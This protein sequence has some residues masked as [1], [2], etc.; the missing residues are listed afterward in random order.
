M[1]YLSI[2]AGDVMKKIL[3]TSIAGAILCMALSCQKENFIPA[4][5]INNSDVPTTGSSVITAGV[6]KTKTALQD[7][8]KVY[9]TNG[10]AICVNGITSAALEL[11]EPVAAASF[12]FE[13]ILAEEKKAVYPA[14]AWTS[15][16]TVT[17]P[18]TQDA[19]TN[20]SF[21]AGA[22]PMVAYAA[23]G[24]DLTFKHTAAVIKLQL[25]KGFTSDEIAYA[26]FFGNNDEQLSGVFSVD[27]ATGA[28]TP[29]STAAADKKVRVTIGKTLSSEV[30][31]VYIAVPAATYSNGF[32]IKVV[33]IN[34]VTMTKRVGTCTLK[35]GSIYP[36]PIDTF[37]ADNTIK[38]FVKS[39]VNV[40]KVW[41]NT[42]GTIDLLQGENYSGGSNNVTNAHYI[43]STTTIMVGEN[44]YNT[45][46]MY[47]LALR[48]YLL[49]RGY[50]GLNTTKYGKNSIPALTGGAVGMS[51][52]IIPNTHD[53]YFGTWPYSETP[54]NG[55]YFYTL[56]GSTK[57]YHTVKVAALDNWAMRSLNFQSGHP[58]T[59]ICSY[60]GT[61]LSGFGGSFCPMR[62]LV[63]YAFFFKYMLDNGYDKGT[64]VGDN[65]LL[66]SELFGK[67]GNY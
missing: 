61:Q 25:K 53:Y 28:L 58:T 7:A 55:G 51:E 24:N 23:S 64:E 34:G 1:N 18:A 36:T 44:V 54:G 57:L 17:I 43:P 19:G 66:R 13:G 52:T 11:T 21:A 33:D 48:C 14:T 4:D 40:L 49:V 10:D 60:S 29:T 42:T 38:A 56:D 39:Y 45:G 63:T 5:D 31:A 22:L 9:W 41:E 12:T 32:K 46:D 62:A 59:N 6:E 37:D 27:Y 30:T 50:D 2:K 8:G 65:V 20:A 47:E 15:D 26:D 67:E 35:K 3:F 16:G